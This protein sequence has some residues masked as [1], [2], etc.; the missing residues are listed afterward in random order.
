MSL[1][2]LK[3]REGQK[4]V[5]RRAATFEARKG[6]TD[7]LIR[8]TE[9]LDIPDAMN[10]HVPTGGVMNP[11]MRFTLI[12]TPRCIGSMPAAFA[13]GS[14]IGTRIISALTGS[15]NVPT[16]RSIAF[17]SSSM[18]NGLLMP[19]RRAEAIV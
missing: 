7:L 3:A 18:I 11:M 6:S 15:M 8:S 10:R 19:D 14:S 4:V 16:T 1:G 2:K 17:M 12:T 5:S 13:I 9:I